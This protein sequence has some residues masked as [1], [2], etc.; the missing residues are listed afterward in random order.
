[1]PLRGGD[2]PR[3]PVRRVEAGSAHGLR[4]DSYPASIPA[5]AQVLDEGL[6][7]GPGVT[8][9]VGENG[10]GKSTLVEAVATAFGL[11]PEGGSVHSRHS[12]RPTESPLGE[13]LQ[14]VRGAG[15]TRWGFFLR[16]E[17]MHGWYS[18]IE[19]HPSTSAEGDV[20]FHGLSHGES[21]LA[22]LETRFSGTGFFCLDEPEA[23]L[24]FS[25]TLG[26]V[27]ALQ[28]VV[29]RRGQVLCATHSPVLAA[30]PGARILEVGEWGLRDS[31]WE[32]LALVD[33]WRRYL[34]EPQA[35][36]RH[37]LD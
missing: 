22:V 36:L 24:S 10:S 27:A 5:V 16:A 21:F 7:L 9:L 19:D 15:S 26:L 18:Y 32:D 13:A 6:D 14:L 33:H 23:A 4:R 12:T 25:S 20:D 37:L 30:M 29:E 17:T 1:M 2:V 31:A 35:Y 28:R 11:S 34:A 8:F 3:H